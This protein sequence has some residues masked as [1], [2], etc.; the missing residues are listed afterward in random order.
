M[1]TMHGSL[2]PHAGVCSLTVRRPSLALR[3]PWVAGQRRNEAL[4]DRDCCDSQLLARQV[5]CTGP[6]DPSG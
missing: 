5:G 2:V 6:G 4:R 3:F 1:W